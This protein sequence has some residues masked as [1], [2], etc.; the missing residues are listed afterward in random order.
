M[1][2]VNIATVYLMT[3]DRDRAS[4]AFT[5]ALAIDPTLARA[6]NGLGV[7]AAERK[8]YP[9]ALEHWKRAV[10]LDPHDFRTLFNIGDLLIAIGRPAEA[11]PYWERYLENAPAVFEASD[12]ARVARWLSKRP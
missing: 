6:H 1:P 7:I 9:A 11:R 5:E 2:V 10:E 4:A 8:D 3:G 12:R